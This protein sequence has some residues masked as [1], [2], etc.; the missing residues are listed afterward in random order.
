M[1]WSPQ[2]AYEDGIPIPR[3]TYKCKGSTLLTKKNNP[4]VVKQ[5]VTHSC[6]LVTDH[7][8]NHCICIC[9]HTFNE[10]ENQDAGLN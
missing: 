6:K 8:G 1:F 5:G 9:G 7:P 3:R 4:N 2:H 10:R